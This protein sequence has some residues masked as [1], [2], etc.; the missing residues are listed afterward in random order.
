MR[1]IAAATLLVLILVGSC[2]AEGATRAAGADTD[3]GISNGSEQRRLDRA[4]R[5]WKRDG[6]RSYAY[7]LTRSCFCPPRRN[8]RIVVRGGRISKRVPRD[9]R[10]Q[11]TVP[12][13]LR[14]IQRA[15]DRGAHRLT[16]SYGR[17]GVP[18]SISIDGRRNVADDEVGWK[19]RRFTPL[20]RRSR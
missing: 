3:P 6:A 17:R 12:R 8:V 5:D 20:K 19:V 18:R 7:R 13:L 4:R 14:T 11:A 9:V 16:V 15:I 1:A 2:V 10:D